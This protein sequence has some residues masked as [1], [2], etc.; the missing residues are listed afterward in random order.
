MSQCGICRAV[1]ARKGWREGAGGEW[2][3]EGEEGRARRVAGLSWGGGVWAVLVRWGGGG[4]VAGGWGVRGRRRVRL[5]L[6]RSGED[7]TAG[8]EQWDRG[9]GLEGKRFFTGRALRQDWG[10]AGLTRWGVWRRWLQTSVDEP[11]VI[12]IVAA[13]CHSASTVEM[14]GGGGAIEVGGSDPQ[15]GLRP[16]SIDREAAGAGVVCL[17]EGGGAVGRLWGG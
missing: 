4:G 13:R 12:C 16:G 7:G 3:I 17:R 9:G 14:D 2:H 15:S 1:E 10:S 5:A 8:R 11:G 6:A